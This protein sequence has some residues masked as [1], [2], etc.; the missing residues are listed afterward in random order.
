MSI[1]ILCI[2][3]DMPYT[4]SNRPTAFGL[5]RHRWIGFSGKGVTKKERYRAAEMSVA[6]SLPSAPL[7]WA[8]KEAL[9]VLATYRHSL[10]AA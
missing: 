1:A 9:F 10:S 6:K 2:T 3:Q 5:Q 7:T 8:Q 4:S